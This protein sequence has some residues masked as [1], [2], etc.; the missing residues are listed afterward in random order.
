M[1][2]ADIGVVIALLAMLAMHFFRGPNR[3]AD[4]I[5]EELQRVRSDQ[6][7]L[8]RE[9]SA[10]SMRV[11]GEHTA[12]VQQISREHYTRADIKDM[13]GRVI[14]QVETL[15]NAVG[16][17]KTAIAVLTGNRNGNRSGH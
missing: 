7:E 14:E 4:D 5:R 3:Q 10:L 15:T 16:E 8:R 2:V 6:G 17:L 1:N 11:S 9:T 12:L 13:L